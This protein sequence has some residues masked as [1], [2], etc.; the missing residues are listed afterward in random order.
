VISVTIM[1]RVA[2]VALLCVAALAGASAYTCNDKMKVRRE[3]GLT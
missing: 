1:A 3:R 2:L